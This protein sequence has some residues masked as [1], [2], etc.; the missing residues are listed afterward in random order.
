[1]FNTQLLAAK[2]LVLIT[3]AQQARQFHKATLLQRAAKHMEN[4]A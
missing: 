4:Y 1:M 3:R 2:W